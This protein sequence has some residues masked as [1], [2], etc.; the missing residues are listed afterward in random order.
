[1]V[2]GPFDFGTGQVPGDLNSIHF[3]TRHD[4]AHWSE[5][6]L[7]MIPGLTWVARGLRADGVGRRGGRAGGGGGLPAD[8]DIPVGGM[9]RGGALAEDGR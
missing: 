3:V 4:T 8:G 7:P 5:L 9:M 6:V 2:L 1:M